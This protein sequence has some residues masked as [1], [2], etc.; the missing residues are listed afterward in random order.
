MRSEENSVNSLELEAL[1]NHA[2]IHLRQHDEFK[3]E[4]VRETTGFSEINAPEARTQP[5]EKAIPFTTNGFLVLWLLNFPGF[6]KLARMRASNRSAM[7]AVRR[8]VFG[9]DL[10]PGGAPRINQSETDCR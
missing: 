6:G 8:E 2:P 5:F 1:F 9:T 10:L 3:Q 7:G 4:W